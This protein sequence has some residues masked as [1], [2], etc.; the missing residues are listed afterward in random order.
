[1][2]VKLSYGKNGLDVILPDTLRIDVFRPRDQQGL[3]DVEERIRHEV[4]NPCSGPT[5]KD[6]IGEKTLKRGVGASDLKSCIVVSDHTR[7]V[8]SRIFIPGLITELEKNGIKRSN[9][10]IL[11]ATGLHR[12]STIDELKRMLGEKIVEELRVV[13]HD[14]RDSNSLVSLGTSSRGTPILLNRMYMDADVKILTGYVDPHFFAGY[15]GGRKAVV[16]GIAGAETIIENHSAANIDHQN[17]RFLKFDGNPIHEDSLEIARKAGV[18]FILNVCLNDRHE[19]INVAAGELEATHRVLVEYMNPI[20]TQTC[21]T[22][23]DIVIVNN[24]GYPLDLNLYQSIKSMTIG[25]MAV[26]AGGTIIAT[27]ELSDGFGPDEFKEIIEGE[28]DP[29]DIIDRL[30]RRDL[31]IGSQWQVQVLARILLRSEVVIVSSLPNRQFEKIRIG[32]KHASSFQDALENAMRKH[33]KMARVLVLPAGPQLIPHVNEK[34]DGDG[35][36]LP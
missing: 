10:S 27:N 2:R 17:A 21:G 13:N 25:E 26:K 33:G 29:R 24:G 31:I 28:N 23:Y 16:P 32:L 36:G 1:M 15:A 8:P 35:S 7:P 34:R 3:Q 18:D 4:T 14:A 30:L 6:I 9:I 22:Y 20:V 12:P 19:I 5:L 11:I